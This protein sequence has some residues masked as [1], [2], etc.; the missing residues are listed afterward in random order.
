MIRF[1]SRIISSILSIFAVI[2]GS[3]SVFAYGPKRPATFTIEKPASYVTFNSIT[4]NPVVGDERDFVR[5]KEVGTEKYV[6]ALEISAGKTY[7]IYAAYHNNAASNLNADG[8]G[9]AKNTRMRGIVPKGLLKSRKTLVSVQ[10]SADNANPK[11]VWDEV[12]LTAKEDV[13]FKYVDGSATIHTKYKDKFGN[14]VNGQKLSGLLTDK[15]ALLGATKLDGE[16]PGCS[17]FSGYVTFQIAA[18]SPKIPQKPEQPKPKTPTAKVTKEVSI[19]ENEYQKEVET[20]D[21]NNISYRIIVENTGEVDIKNLVLSDKLPAGM[22]I[23]KGSIKI[24]RGDGKLQDISTVDQTFD[25]IK[26]GQKII[27]YY[28]VGVNGI[29]C[30]DNSFENIATIKYIDKDMMDSAKL[31]IKKECEEATPPP[32]PAPKNKI[33]ETGPAEIAIVATIILGL[34]GGIGYFIYSK[35]VL[36]KKMQNAMGIQETTKQK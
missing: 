33:P 2:I 28:K 32:T 1:K 7:E 11:A 6:N 19:I 14:S 10:I 21:S 35:K 17:E 22:E 12:S 9:V 18:M 23:I 30:G 15:G 36:K 4:N 24:D 13:S 29:K 31:T 8:R 27:I 34:G 5:V 16:L 3:T 26:V 25:N 20:K